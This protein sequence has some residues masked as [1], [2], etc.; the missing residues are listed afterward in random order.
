[1]N[2]EVLP[3]IGHSIVTLDTYLDQGLSQAEA[4]YQYTVYLGG[5][6]T[7]FANQFRRQVASVYL[8]QSWRDLILEINGTHLRF[9]DFAEWL[10][11]VCKASGIEDQA[12]SGLL[13]LMNRVVQRAANGELQHTVEDILALDEGVAQRLASA[14]G[15]VPR[16]YPDE[17]SEKIDELIDA[18][19]S[20]PRSGFENYLQDMGLKSRRNDLVPT[21]IVQLPNGKTAYYIEVSREQRP[22]IEFALSRRIIPQVRSIESV[23]ESLASYMEVDNGAE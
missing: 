11:V 20:L 10:E 14:A 9:T 15:S 12:R 5:Q 8:S 23:I 7:S 2:I 21:S 3:A 17:V 13:S 4:D 16:I 22:I 19:E 6:I 1:M 18:A